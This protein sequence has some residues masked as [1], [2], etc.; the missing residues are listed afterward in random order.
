[1][2]I[3][4]ARCEVSVDVM[5]GLSAAEQAP[6]WRTAV[7]W[8]VLH[9]DRNAVLVNDDRGPVRLPTTELPGSIWLGD[10]PV[11][12]AAL[13][14]LGVDGIL[15]GCRERVEH[16]DS[17]VQFLTMLAAHRS[18]S[19]PVPPATRWADLDEVADLVPTGIRRVRAG[20]P[21]W[22]A[23]GWFPATETWLRE[24]LAGLGPVDHRSNR[25]APQLG[26]VERAEGADD[27]R[28]GMAQGLS[29]IIA[30]H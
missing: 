30:V 13:T 25:T 18:A 14:E 24:Q 23:P 5:D 4:P 27:I 22:E 9:P 11:L 29:R 7:S 3:E 15:L 10:A 8:I 20:R 17:H 1:L 2:I 16:P 21:P 6:P 28:A 26:A 19:A 12:S